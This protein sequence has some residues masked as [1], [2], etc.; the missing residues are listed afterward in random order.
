LLSDATKVVVGKDKIEDQFPSKLSVMPEGLFKN[1]TEQEIADL[2][3]FLE[4]SRSNPEPAVT[5]K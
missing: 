2:F 3:G 4:T 5:G 1:L